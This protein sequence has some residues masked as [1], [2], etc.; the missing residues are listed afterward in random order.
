MKP[1]E[2]ARKLAALG[3]AADAVRAYTLSLQAE[4]AA[5]SE[6]LEA[7]AYILQADGDYRVA[8]TAFLSLH[9]EGQFREETSAM[10]RGAFYEPNVKL[11]KSRYERN[12]K[13]LAK[14]PYLFRKDFPA[15]EDLPIQFF[16]YDDNN[17]YVPFYPAEGRFGEFVNVRDAVIRRNFFRDLEKPVLAVDVFSQYELEYLRDNVRRSEDVGRENHVYLHYTDWGTFCAWLQVLSMRP[18]LEEK[19]L[20]FLIGDEIGQYPLD[21]QTRFGIDYGKYPPKPVGIREVHRLIWHTQLS[22]HNGG[23]FFNEVFDSHPNL[24]ALPSMMFY[25]AEEEIQRTRELLEKARALGPEALQFGGRPDE[26]GRLLRELASLRDVTDKDILVAMYI[27]NSRD[28]NKDLDKNSRISPALFFQPHFYSINYQVYADKAGNAVMTSDALDQLHAS[29]LFRD[30]RYIKT[31]TPMRRPTVSYAAALRFMYV[32][33]KARYVREDGRTSNVVPDAFA[34]RL[35]NRSYL[36]DPEDRLYHDSTLVRFEDGKLNPKATFTALAAFL[37]LPY[38]ESM[39][40]CSEMGEPTPEGF[41][42]EPVYRTYEDFADDGERYLLE[43]LLRDVYEAYGYDFQYYDGRPVEGQRL[44]EL[45]RGCATLEKYMR[46]TWGEYYR[47]SITISNSGRE[48]D[49]QMQLVVDTTVERTMREFQEKRLAVARLLE[50]NLRFINSNG[51]PLRFMER[52]KP[53]EALLE[54]PLYH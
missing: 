8:Y 31:F 15:F 26:E 30:F 18:L 28:W 1:I 24:L 5:P 6:R 54:R 10:L 52:L 2:I 44:E 14:Y 35:C 19:K 3:E 41:S 39:E 21:F 22:A 37:D 48:D 50:R 23:D 40:R 13:L 27:N 20:V 53:D 29:P 43:Y 9:R 38:T 36:I 49:G 12:R 16:P 51:Q 42:L 17:G 46:E 4:D 45:V 32:C 11:L 7:A 25:S 47:D 34:K 33:A